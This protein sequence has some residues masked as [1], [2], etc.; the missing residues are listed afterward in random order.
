MNVILTQVHKA[1][2]FSHHY[3]KHGGQHES[4]SSM[5][6][7]LDVKSL[8]PTFAP[9]AIDESPVNKYNGALRDEIEVSAVMRK[10]EEPSEYHKA[11]N[12]VTYDEE[13]IA[14]SQQA[15]RTAVSY[16]QEAT[17][18]TNYTPRNLTVLQTDE[19]SLSVGGN[20]LVTPSP[21]IDNSSSKIFSFGSPITAAAG[22]TSTRAPRTP[23]LV[24]P[25]R[26]RVFSPVGLTNRNEESMNDLMS[27]VSNIAMNEMSA[28]PRRDPNS[29]LFR[30]S[31]M[32]N[33]KE[34]IFSANAAVA[35]SGPRLLTHFSA[36]KTSKLK[37]PLGDRDIDYRRVE[38][39]SEN[40]SEMSL[41]RVTSPQSA[42]SLNSKSMSV[43]R[44]RTSEELNMFTTR[45][46]LQIR[47]PNNEDRDDHVYA[48]EV[49]ANQPEEPR[50]FND[51][52][53]SP[54]QVSRNLYEDRPFSL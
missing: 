18:M 37:S 9:V 47:R 10:S 45:E 46:P 52:N 42:L 6:E 36:S 28:G 44:T 33:K 34:V 14:P 19:N 48:P 51:E 54:N 2:Y 29:G 8:I 27:G 13:E 21:A 17:T 39:V 35:L 11:N 23:S 3:R 16:N 32:S 24:Q 12:Y 43:I 53:L 7:K 1:D 5:G 4:T 49:R 25:N 20:P 26:A 38:R 41:K 50:T 31:W 30:P 22:K 15:V 40:L